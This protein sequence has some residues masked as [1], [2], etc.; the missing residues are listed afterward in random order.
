MTAE[1]INVPAPDAAD[2][3]APAASEP[4]DG[5]GAGTLWR[6]IWWRAVLVPLTVLAPIV[7]LAPTADHRFNL[8]W[9]GGLFRDD[10]LGLVPHTLRSLEGYLGMGNF[11][12]LGRMLEKSLDLA[13]Y[14]LSDLS[15]IPVTVS[16]R[17]VSFLGAIALTAATVLFAESFLTRGRLFRRPPSTVAAAVPFAVGGGLVAAGSA[18]PVVLFGGLYLTSAAL[19]LVVGALLCRIDPARRLRWWHL[20]L[21]VLGGAALACFNEIAYLALPFATAAVLVRGRGVPVRVVALLWSGFLPVFLA[22]RVVIYRHC[23]TGECYRGS[24]I[25][26]GPDVLTAEP[27]RLVAWLP[28]LMWRAATDG[29]PWLVGLVPVLA[30]VVLALLAWWAIRDLPRL[31]TVDRRRALGL[32]AAAFA[33]LVLGATIGALNGDVQRLVGRGEWG[34]GWR[35]T[36]ITAA[37]GAVVLVAL[38]HAWSARRFATTGLI[39][40]LALSATLSAAANKRYADTLGHREPAILANRLAQEMAH[41]DTS[42]AGDAHRCALRAEFFVLYADSPFSLRRFDQSLDVAAR[43]QAGVPFCVVAVPL[44]APGPSDGAENH[45][46]RG[47]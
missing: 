42:P 20:G 1:T 17:L 12:P 11:R 40:L 33:L 14:T 45:N 6:R 3:P 30:F 24:D 47:R 9:H 39:V 32:A 46:R 28:P 10:P 31:S 37:A 21:L 44:P 8:Y 25:A 35:D 18:S 2:R 27:V 26:L 13:A 15:G 19:V 16:F 41:F 29:R 22:V 5:P 34:Q 7:A 4:S 43:Q 23:S 36:A 38:V